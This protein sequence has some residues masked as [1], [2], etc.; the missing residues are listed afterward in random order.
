MT[1]LAGRADA[2]RTMA[3]DNMTAYNAVDV[4]VTDFGTFNMVLDRYCDQ[5]LV[6]VLQP[7]M[8]SVQYL[9]DFQTVDIAKDG[10]SDKKM[11]VVEYGLQCNNEAAN[12]KIRYTTG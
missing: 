11:L 5:D 3:D 4:Y 7:D 12:G 10:D 1:G 6:Y 2:V 8:W 9:R